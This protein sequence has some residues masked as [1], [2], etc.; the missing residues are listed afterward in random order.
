[1]SGTKI[2]NEKEEGAIRVLVCAI[3][4]HEYPLSIMDHVGFRR[5]LDLLQPLFEVPSWNTLK[6]EIFNV[7]QDEEQM[8]MK[9]LDTKEGRVAITL[10]IWIQRNFIG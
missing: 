5:L 4:M 9:M 6:K 8:V 2:T 7:Y 1:M 3:I 10:D